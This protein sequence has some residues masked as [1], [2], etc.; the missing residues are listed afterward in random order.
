MEL[1]CNVSRVPLGGRDEPGNLQLVA[2]GG[3]DEP[4]NLQLVDSAVNLAVGEANT[5]EWALANGYGALLTEPP[6]ADELAASEALPWWDGKVVFDQTV[7]FLA[8][9]RK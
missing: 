1:P 3:R 6:T 7:W 8:S 4:G 9:D 5:R 2:L